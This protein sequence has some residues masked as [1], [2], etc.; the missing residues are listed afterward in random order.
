MNHEVSDERAIELAV[1]YIALADW[2]RSRFRRTEERVPFGCLVGASEF[3]GASLVSE[4]HNAVLELQELK[5][6]VDAHP[7]IDA[8][9]VFVSNEPEDYETGVGIVSVC[10]EPRAKLAARFEGRPKRVIR[11]SRANITNRGDVLSVPQYFVHTNNTLQQCVRKGRP[12]Y[13]LAPEYNIRL[14][15]AL[16]RTA[17]YLQGINERM[18]SVY[19]AHEGSI[20]IRFCTDSTGVKEVFRLRDIPNGASRRS[21]VLHWVRGHWRNNGVSDPTWVKAFLRG[22]TTFCWNG[23]VCKIR[24]SKADSLL[25]GWKSQDRRK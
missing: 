2:S 14:N 7:L 4:R 18:W 16:I 19:L 13:V 12:N 3:D 22:G 20:G 10:D 24:P 11:I 23:L 17:G 25:A 8:R 6:T 21:A 5:H 1:D 9:F 15:D